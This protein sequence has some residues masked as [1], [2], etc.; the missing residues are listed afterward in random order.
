MTTPS[1]QAP[2]LPNVDYNAIDDDDLYFPL[3]DLEYATK[4]NCKFFLE[5]LKEA[6]L[7]EHLMQVPEL[8]VAHL[9]AFLGAIL[10][11]HTVRQAEEL[12]PAIIHLLQHQAN[13]AYD[14]FN[15]HPINSTV[16]NEEKKKENLSRLR[17]A[18]P[19]SIVAQTM[20]LGRLILDMMEELRDNWQ[21]HFQRIRPPKQEEH[22]CS[23]ET[24][25]KLM[26][27]IGSK[28]CAKW[29]EELG[30]L[31]ENYALNQMAIQIGW[32]I[33]YFSHLSVKPPHE[34]HYFDYGLPL[35]STYRKHTF[36]LM[37]TY[38]NATLKQA[39]EDQQPFQG[40]PE[41]QTLL[42]E[43]HQ[44]SEKTS[45]QMPP[46]VSDFQKDTAIVQASIEKDLMDLIMSGY[47]VK[48][49][50]MSLFYFWYTLDAPLRAKDPK[51]VDTT[52]ALSHMTPMIALIKAT[53]Q[54]LPD[55]DLTP[56]IKNL[57]QKMQALKD[58]FSDPESLDQ[59]SKETAQQQAEHI[60]KTI[61]AITCEHI[62]KG[63]HLEILANVLF[64]YWLRFSVYFGVSESEWQKMD[65]Y[66][67]QLIT[68]ARNYLANNL[69]AD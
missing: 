59:V 66:F 34:T 23:Y 58:R 47:E 2:M 39:E 8:I 52:D 65:Y 38:T 64:H 33:G 16:K 55:P 51:A 28:Q 50:L 40:D 4:E 53:L 69:T 10:T 22:F 57:N 54:E 31:S 27:L 29:R 35:I 6:L 9:C 63:V 1:Y 56:E 46:A 13:A 18:A 48:M 43:I 12:E 61:H 44:L 68:A 62:E 5:Q 11:I 42:K 24:L 25:L 30:D 19:G 17:E 67:S 32:L 3:I 45:A 14:H 21:A 37:E 20:R 49:I 60:N 41:A 15:Q 26:L 36:K 7:Q